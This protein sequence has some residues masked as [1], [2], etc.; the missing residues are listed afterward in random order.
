MIL[1]F[2]EKPCFVGLGKKVFLMIVVKNEGFFGKLLS[3]GGAIFLNEGSIRIG[4]IAVF[5]SLF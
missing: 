1:R 2:S 3:G 5:E 4:L